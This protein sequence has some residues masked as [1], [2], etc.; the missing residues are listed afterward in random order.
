ML[1]VLKPNPHRWPAG[2]TRATRRAQAIAAARDAGIG[3]P[4][5]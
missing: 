4:P 2:A 1:F 5:T 3:K